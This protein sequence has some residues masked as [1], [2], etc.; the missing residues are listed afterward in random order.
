MP[1]A[2]FTCLRNILE[3]NGVAVRASYDVKT[4]IT[5]YDNMPESVQ[6]QIQKCNLN[7]KPA[8]ARCEGAYG[9]NNC[10]QITPA[11]FQTKCDKYFKRV[12]CCHC[13]ME[14]PEGYTEDD[15]HCIKP[16][17]KSTPSF[18]SLKECQANGR[19]CEQRG[20]TFTP[21]CGIQ[22]KRVGT[23][24]CFPVCPNGWHDEGKRCRKP[25][26]Y[27]MAQPFIWQ[28]GDN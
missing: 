2:K 1:T 8:Q 14:C 18:K 26:D 27:R 24:G 6:T 4:L 3:L 12:G 16:E 25:A 21:V 19:T 23:T 10:E 5:L 28:Q 7:L 20:T 13:A 22:Y 9:K 15:Y 17:Q 11:A